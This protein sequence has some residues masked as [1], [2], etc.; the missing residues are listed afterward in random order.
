MSSWTYFI[1]YMKYSVW[2]ALQSY[3]RQEEG[4]GGALY[5]FLCQDTGGNSSSPFSL[6][7]LIIS[8]ETLKLWIRKTYLL[9]PNLTSHLSELMCCPTFETDGTLVMRPYVTK[10]ERGVSGG[11]GHGLGCGVW[12]S[13]HLIHEIWNL[14]HINMLYLSKTMRVLSYLWKVLKAKS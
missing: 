10:E 4:G 5:Y 3:I 1:Y 9:D 13:V 8:F 7:S 2:G 11:V 14:F 6:Y 12:G